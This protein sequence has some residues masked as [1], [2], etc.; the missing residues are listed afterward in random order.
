MVSLLPTPQEKAPHLF[1]HFRG[2]KGPSTEDCDSEA[3]ME[4]LKEQLKEQL[5]SLR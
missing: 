2:P 5:K 3:V 1:E 4:K